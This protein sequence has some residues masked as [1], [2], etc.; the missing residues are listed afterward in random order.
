MPK[1][2]KVK[3]TG[4]FGSRYGLSIRQRVLDVEEKQRG[5]HECPYCSKKRVKR[6]AAGIWQCRSCNVK[7]TGKAYAIGV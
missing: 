5:W 3:S 2:K 4:R 1:T 7:F 6:V